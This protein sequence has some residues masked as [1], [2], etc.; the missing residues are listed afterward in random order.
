MTPILQQLTQVAAKIESAEGQAETLQAADAFLAFN[1]PVPGSD[2]DYHRLDPVKEHMSPVPVAIGR[3]EGQVRIVTELVGSGSPGTAPFWGKLI[4][5]C[6]F[7][8]TVNAGVS[9]IYTPESDPN[10]IPSL[11]LGVYLGGVVLHKVWGARGRLRLIL[12]HNRVGL[13][14][15]EFWG[16]DF[17][18]SDS[19]FLS[20]VSY[21][22]VQP[23]VF[24]GATFT[25]DGYAAVIS[26]LEY[27][28]NA[29]LKRRESVGASSGYLATLITDRN[30]QIRFNPEAV[31]VATKDFFG[32]WRN[33]STAAMNCQLGTVAGN[34]IQIQAPKVQT[35]KVQTGSR[36]RLRTWEILGLCTMD[37]AGDDEFSITLT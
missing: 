18:V 32:M 20:G 28:T 26:R 22:T 5:A 29:N 4:R 15:M 8:E 13:L 21:P 12:A 23:P 7:K 11:T 3:R 36:N 37:S 17:S 1:L 2:I 19:G 16:C 6:G 14:D 31:A 34:Q 9:V 24:Q 25:F 35:L 30:P 33:G 27:L 10:Q